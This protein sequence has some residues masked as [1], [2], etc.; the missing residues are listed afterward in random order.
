[1]DPCS[2]QIPRRSEPHLHLRQWG[3]G[4]YACLLIHGFGDGCY[5]W[6]EF[7]PTIASHYKT[8]AIDLRGHGDSGWDPHAQYDV[9]THARDVAHVIDNL[10]LNSL[11]LVGHSMGGDIAIQVAIHSVARILGLVLVDFGPSLNPVGARH[12]AAEFR[13]TSRMIYRCPSEYVSWLETTRPLVRS[14]VLQSLASCALRRLVDGSFALKADPAMAPENDELGSP[15]REAALWAGLSNMPWPVLVVRGE[16][17]AVL[18]RGVAERMTEVLPYGHRQS[19]PVAGHAVMIDNPDG[20]AKT[21]RP[22]LL[23]LLVQTDIVG[24]A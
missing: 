9:E 13:N 18:P 5:V 23:E 2:V 24:R 21:V 12:V 1:M 17:S 20:F 19:V 10:G 8:F 14:D 4:G 6:N 7:A 22:F 3:S 16:G 15:S 11:V